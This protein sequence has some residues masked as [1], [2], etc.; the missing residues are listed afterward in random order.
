MLRRTSAAH[1]PITMA[2]VRIGIELEFRVAG[3]KHST[4]KSSLD[5]GDERRSDD[6]SDAISTLA[7]DGSQSPDNLTET[8]NEPDLDDERWPTRPIYGKNWEHVFE[9]SMLH[10]CETLASLGLPVTVDVSED[11]AFAGPLCKTAP[12]GSLVRD[13]PRRVYRVWNRQQA[14]PNNSAMRFDYWRVYHEPCAT[15]NTRPPTDEAA[16]QYDWAAFEIATSIQT[17]QAELDNGLPTFR[18]AIA[19]LRNSTQILLHEEGGFHIHASPLGRDLDPV[20]AKRITALAFLLE[21]GLLFKMCHSERRDTWLADAIVPVYMQAGDDWAEEAELHELND[22]AVYTDRVRQFRERRTL[23]HHLDPNDPRMY[24]ALYTLF[25]HD[26]PAGGARV[27]TP[28]A[29]ELFNFISAVG[30]T[31]YGSVKFRHPEASFDGDFISLWVDVVRRLVDL[32]QWEQEA[33]CKVLVKL[34][35]LAT[36]RQQPG[37]DE[38]L[39]ALGMSDRA[40]FVKRRKQLY[41]GRLREHN[42]STILPKVDM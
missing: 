41:G 11:T 12:L 33:Y 3:S 31:D 38:Y 23:A 32:A 28:P 2:P 8:K 26:S 7:P 6:Q 17:D 1:P 5:F 10:V 13:N 21:D 22:C 15:I 18:R 36:R 42:D 29:Q 16:S 19:A 27:W 24:L 20:T 14:V 39:H 37:V 35:D 30:V 34:Y 4:Q 40:E 9:E 25:H